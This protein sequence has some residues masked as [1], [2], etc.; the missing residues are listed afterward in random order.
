MTDFTLTHPTIEES[1]LLCKLFFESVNPFIHVIHQGLFAR[2][3]ERFRRGTFFLP[4]EFEA[5][6]FSVYTLIFEQTLLRVLSQ[7]PNTIC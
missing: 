3:L 7:Y 2:E 1:N 4:L 6:L 5:L